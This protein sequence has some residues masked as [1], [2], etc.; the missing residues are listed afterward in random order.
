MSDR[1]DRRYTVDEANAE[2]A[3]LREHLARLR[4]ARQAMIRAGQRITDAVATDG[5]GVQGRDWFDSG[6]TLKAE[7][8]WL[9]D[10]NI[11]L[12]DPETGLVDFPADRE[13]REVYLCW[14]LGEDRVGWWHELDTGFVGRKPL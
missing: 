2:L 11:L 8:E 7:V 12:R 4:E 6:R 9:N 13:G 3:N 14:R 1:D 10:R 5:G